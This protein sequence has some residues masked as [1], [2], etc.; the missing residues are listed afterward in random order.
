MRKP[1]LC[2][3]AAAL[4]LSACGTTTE[5]RLSN[6]MQAAS[7]TVSAYCALT[8]EGRAEIRR[9]IGLKAQLYRCPGDPIPADPPT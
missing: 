5:E 8:P 2:A 3:L 4:A 6:G 9:Q 1:V 7:I